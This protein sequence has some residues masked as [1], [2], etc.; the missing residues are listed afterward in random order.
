ML[1]WAAFAFAQGLSD[2]DLNLLRNPS[3][4]NLNPR[5]AP[6][7]W[8]TFVEPQPGAFAELDPLA[9]T[10]EWAALV[11][12]PER[13]ETEPANNWSQVIVDGVAG[14]E[15]VLSG[16]VRTEAATEAA[17][18]LQ[19]FSRD[20]TR[21]V[22]ANSTENDF[23]VQGSTD[24]QRVET[25]V[26]APTATEFVVVRC[27]LKGRGTAWFDD[28]ML[29]ALAQ[30][31]PAL[32]PLEPVESIPPGESSPPEL[33]RDLAQPDLLEL[34]TMLQEA[35]RELRESNARLLKRVT[36][37][38]SELDEARMEAEAA[39]TLEPIGPAIRHPLVPHVPDEGNAP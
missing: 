9:H 33:P 26:T 32:D 16:Y 4:E 30:D 38:Q 2:V 39:G 14:K 10:G 3:F 13:Y 17:L 35:V 18:W 29:V 12:N 1:A 31:P 25:Y 22:A 28:L 5:A 24:W 11:H 23:T 8:S 37:I 21:V 6:V 7:A 19:C 36:E 27:V 20:P 15:L 34:S